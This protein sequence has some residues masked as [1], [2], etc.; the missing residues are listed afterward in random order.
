VHFY[1]DNYVKKYLTIFIPKR[2]TQEGRN[3]KGKK[4][5]LGVTSSGRFLSFFQI[6]FD[7]E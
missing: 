7:V 2:T 6:F 1:E 3:G 4:T 5:E